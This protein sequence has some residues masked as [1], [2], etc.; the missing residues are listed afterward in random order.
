MIAIA[1]AGASAGVN[2]ADADTICGDVDNC[3][4]VSNS[5]QTDSDGDGVY[6][7]VDQCP[8]TPEGATVEYMT[9]YQEQ[10]EEIANIKMNDLNAVDMDGAVR[11]IEGTCRSMG[12]KVVTELLSL[13][14][15]RRVAV[16][17]GGRLV[18]SAR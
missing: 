12:V 15:S 13:A 2:D 10:V 9:R 17:S 7:G 8:G 4:A 3:P 11:Q 14:K 18:V 16:E 6:D 5:A 1:A